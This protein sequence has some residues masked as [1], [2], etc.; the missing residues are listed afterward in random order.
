MRKCVK[1][2]ISNDGELYTCYNFLPD[3][4]YS[5]QVMIDYCQILTEHEHFESAYALTYMIL[6]Y[7]YLYKDL[8]YQG[9]C[10]HKYIEQNYKQNKEQ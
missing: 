7:L 6:Y 2:G 10:F 9:Y 1:H 4:K 3:R 5:V 8:K